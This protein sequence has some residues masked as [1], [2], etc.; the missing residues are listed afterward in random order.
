MVVQ[1]SI[2]KMPVSEPAPDEMDSLGVVGA[3]T[4]K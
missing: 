3:G 2:T 4:E 1:V